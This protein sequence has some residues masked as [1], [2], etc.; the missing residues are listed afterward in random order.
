V[1]AAVSL[2]AVDDVL[3]ARLLRRLEGGPPLA[4]G[5]PR[6]EDK[7]ALDARHRGALCFAILADG[8]VVGTC[9]T[10]GRV[11]PSGDVEVGWGLVE[12]ARGLGVGTAAVALLIDELAVALPGTPLVAR[13]EWETAA[14]A[15]VAVSLASERLLASAGFTGGPVPLAPGS[16]TWRLEVS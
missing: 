3:E 13:T 14:G 1:S 2:A 15:L 5:F 10:H 7:V 8:V 12:S 16:R 9:G 6:H 4:G 11:A